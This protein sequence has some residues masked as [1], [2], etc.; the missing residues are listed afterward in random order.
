MIAKHVIVENSA[1]HVDAQVARSDLLTLIGTKLAVRPILN[2]S[3]FR[4]RPDYGAAS[5]THRSF[6]YSVG[7]RQHLDASKSLHLGSGCQPTIAD[8]AAR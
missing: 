5:L 6:R 3:D 4:P 2:Q 7:R 8:K 1:K